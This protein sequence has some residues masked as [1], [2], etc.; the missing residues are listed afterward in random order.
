[1]ENA[2]S[3]QNEND[4]LQTGGGLLETINKAEM[5]NFNTWFNGSSRNHRELTNRM[6]PDNLE[7]ANW[8]RKIRD[9][10]AFHEDVPK[11]MDSSDSSNEMDSMTAEE[12]ET[13]SNNM[14]NDESS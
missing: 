14:W 3:E 4:I 11:K 12:A 10:I 2:F 9:G 7:G 13:K 1:M 6:D 8:V 5:K